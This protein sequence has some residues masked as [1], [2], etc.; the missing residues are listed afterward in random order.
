MKH[1]RWCVAHNA[2]FTSPATTPC[3]GTIAGI[4][5]APTWNRTRVPVNADTRP[6]PT[7]LSAQ[8]RRIFRLYS[9]YRLLIGLVLAV[10]ISSELD[11]RLLDLAQ[12]ELFRNASWFYLIL[13]ALIAALVPRPRSMVQVFS[14]AVVDVLLLS[15]L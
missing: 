5:A 7:G 9:L 10:L 4:A 8:G 15:C 1:N 14:L 12:P 11:D 13:N 3:P 2:V 6:L